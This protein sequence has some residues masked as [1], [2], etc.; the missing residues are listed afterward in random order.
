M[1]KKKRK[2]HNSTPKT[3]NHNVYS[4]QIPDTILN[5]ENL[6][7]LQLRLMNRTWHGL[8]GIFSIV[9]WFFLLLMT[10]IFPEGSSL[11]LPLSMHYKKITDDPRKISIPQHQEKDTQL[12]N[13]KINKVKRFSKLEFEI[14]RK[15][16]SFW[17]LNYV[18]N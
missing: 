13:G 7:I 16:Q 17:M 4:I 8:S 15:N 18:E 10:S 1:R 14:V 5:K 6:Q 12:Q 2:I 11:S 9:K 3:I